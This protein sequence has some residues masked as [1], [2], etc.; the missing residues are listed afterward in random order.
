MKKCFFIFLSIIA[1][2]STFAQGKIKVNV[3]D[4]LTREPLSSGC[5][6]MTKP[7]SIRISIP[8]TNG[9]VV[10]DRAPGK[11]TIIIRCLGY[12]TKTITGVVVSEGKTAYVV[13]PLR[14]DREFT[15]IEQ[16]KLGL[17]PE[18]KLTKK[19]RKEL[20]LKSK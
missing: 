13:F 3:T 7:D 15:R 1:V 14:P 8:D 12:M 19:E 5:T 10:F 18:K 11:Y 20:G 16:Y 4:E 17:L 2:V 6:I 9:N